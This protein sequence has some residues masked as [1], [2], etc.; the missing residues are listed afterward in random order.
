ML[1][2]WDAIDPL[3]FD[4]DLICQ[5]STDYSALETSGNVCRN[6]GRTYKLKKHLSR[7]YT[8][9]CLKK[10]RFMCPYC[11]QKSKRRSNIHNHIKKLHPGSRCYAID[12]EENT[13][14]YS[15]D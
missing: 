14:M 12:I 1:S 6:C 3:A 5:P 15:D 4:S 2:V 7:H 9:E 10:P 13:V 8:Y 11:L